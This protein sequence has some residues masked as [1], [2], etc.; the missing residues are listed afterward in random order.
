[1]FDQYSEDA[2][3]AIFWARVIAG[4]RGAQTIETEDLLAA[5]VEQDQRPRGERKRPMFFAS[6]TADALLQAVDRPPVGPAVPHGTDMAISR[7]MQEVLKRASEIAGQRGQTTV[8]PL[9][10]LAAIMH[11]DATRPSQLL[12]ENG[13]TDH[14]LEQALAG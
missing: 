13:I 12:R 3:I 5:L 6:K 10:L 9:H 8:T 1:M 7:P 2:R 4:R 14:S 11:E